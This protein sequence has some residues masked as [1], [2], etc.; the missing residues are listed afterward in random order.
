MPAPHGLV[1]PR[2]D[3]KKRRRHEAMR[4]ARYGTAIA[5]GFFLTLSL[6]TM[7]RSGMMGQGPMDQPG[8]MRESSPRGPSGMMGSGTIGTMEGGGMGAHMGMM[9]PGPMLRMLKTE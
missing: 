8:G 4:G 5:I 3:A 6:P 7:G 9:E 1:I 2:G